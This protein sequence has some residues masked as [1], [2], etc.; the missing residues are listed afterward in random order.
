M[1]D[2]QRGDIVEISWKDHFRYS[3]DRPEEM[4][5]KSWGQV[6]DFSEDGIG[7]VQNEVQNSEEAKADRVLDGQFIL[8]HN[9]ISVKI[10]AGNR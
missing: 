6:D 1:Q 5:V 9:I 8:I 7:I 4:I 2:L 3:A 10:L